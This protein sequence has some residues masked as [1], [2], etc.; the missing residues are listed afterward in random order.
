MLPLVNWVYTLIAVALALLLLVV[1]IKLIIRYGQGLIR[2][3]AFALFSV[4][5]IGLVI[6]VLGLPEAFG[7]IKQGTLFF[8]EG[9]LYLLQPWST[10]FWS[11]VF[12]IAS[13]FTF[14]FAILE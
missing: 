9:N 6:N 4:L 11:A 8:N 5:A 10:I 2:I 7:W 13:Y 1:L 14:R 12:G 3:S